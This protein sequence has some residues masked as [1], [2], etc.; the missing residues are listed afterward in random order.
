MAI[1]PR[2][3]LLDEP[4]GAL[5]AKVRKELRLWLREI[6]DRTGLTTVFVTHDQ[7]KRWSSPTA[8]PSSTPAASSR[9]AT[10]QECSERPGDAV[11]ARIPRR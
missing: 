9:S 4:F 1:E 7:A 6:H 2:V 5:D 8:S 3:L 10:P 11:R